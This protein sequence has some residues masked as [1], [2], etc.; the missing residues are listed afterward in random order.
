[1]HPF[2]LPLIGVD[3]EAFLKTQTLSPITPWME[4]GNVV[5][6]VAKLLKEETSHELVLDKVHLWVGSLRSVIRPLDPNDKQ[7]NQVMLG[8][9]YI[10]SEGVIH[11]DLRGVRTS[12]R[13]LIHDLSQKPI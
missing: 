8:L 2:I 10:H 6:A 13:R 11:G 7:I 12:R 1:M 3:T 5:Q 4:K 9:G